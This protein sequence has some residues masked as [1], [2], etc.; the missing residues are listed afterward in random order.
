MSKCPTCSKNTMS[1]TMTIGGRVRTV[2]TGK[3]KVQHKCEYC[4][5]VGWVESASSAVRTL[6][7]TK[8]QW[9]KINDL[10]EING[11]VELRKSGVKI[12][13]TNE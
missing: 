7:F 5:G 1:N 4:K 8:T 3:V 11:E 9:K 6:V 10:I 2:G 13:V 12:V